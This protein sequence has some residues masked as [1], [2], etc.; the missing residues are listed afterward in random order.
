[1]A[2]APS[3]PETAGGETAPKKKS[4]LL[5]V[6]IIVLLLVAL[7]IGGLLGWRWWIV[8]SKGGGEHSTDAPPVRVDLPKPPTFVELDPFT[9]NL[10][11]DEGD[12]Y[13]QVVIALR[14]ADPKL[15][16]GLKGFM[17]EIR[18]RINMLLSSKLPSEVTTI[19]GREL[20]ALNIMDETNA[21]LGYPPTP[22][23]SG[24][25]TSNGPVQAV[26]FNSFII[27]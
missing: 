11:R 10:H 17:P 9:V 20:L 22:D 18:H 25:L 23:S 5:L 13:L 19:E 27:Q 4:K 2:K 1:M 14:V 26:L 21:A 3:K 15:G 8:K 7:L 6:L 24:R 16:D 12:H